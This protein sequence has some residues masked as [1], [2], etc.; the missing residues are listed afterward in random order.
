MWDGVLAGLR[1]DYVPTD[2]PDQVRIYRNDGGLKF[3]EIG[4]ES[5]FVYPIG[6]MAANAGDLDNDGH[7][8]LYFATGNPDI[9][10]LE[11]NV[12]YMN[13]G[14]GYFVDRTR[15]AGVGILGKGHGVTMLDWDG[16][17]YL[18][19]YAVVGGF[20]HG[21]YWRDALL[22]QR[23][24]EHNH[25]L[26]VELSQDGHNK[27]AVGAAVTVVSG[28]LK[29]YQEVKNGRGFGSSDPPI[30]HYGLGK[31]LRVEKLTIRWPDGTT[32]GYPPPPVDK[33]IRIRKGD[34]TWTLRPAY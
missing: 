2:D 26:E 1:S 25:W 3:T 17:G 9:R 31:N 20:Y 15:S 32:V 12:L 13:N 22:P 29:Q 19:M 30:L 14:H 21:D 27:Q 28:D 18:D 4:R 23:R 6:R 16:D 5:G 34:P 33:K 24:A 8:D 11:P 10:R 7:L